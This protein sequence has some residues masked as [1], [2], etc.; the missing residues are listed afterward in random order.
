M[1]H[2]R[3]HHSRTSRNTHLRGC[4]GRLATVLPDNRLA[5]MHHTVGDASPPIIGEIC[6]RRMVRASGKEC[7]W[8]S[9]RSRRGNLGQRRWLGSCCTSGAVADKAR[10][11]DCLPRLQADARSPFGHHSPVRPTRPSSS[12]QARFLGSQHPQLF[13]TDADT[14][15]HSL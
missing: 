8:A 3:T 1:R 6:L 2:S 9:C 15:I 14:A 12:R 11:G 7:G 5:D 4:L 13:F 10:Q